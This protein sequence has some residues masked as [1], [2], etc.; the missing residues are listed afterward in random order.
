MGHLQETVAMLRSEVR[1]WT[2]ATTRRGFLRKAAI[3][4]GSAAAGGG[5]SNRQALDEGVTYRSQWTRWTGKGPLKGRLFFATSPESSAKFEFSGDRVAGIHEV[6]PDCGLAEVLIDREPAKV[7]EIDTY[8]PQVEWN[9]RTDLAVGQP[10]GKHLVTVRVAARK[11]PASSNC[12]NM[13]V[14]GFTTE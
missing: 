2:R 6:G 13:Q 1:T 14:V 8:A 12:Y 10:P 4:V 9:R 11:N 5:L 7:P 3:L